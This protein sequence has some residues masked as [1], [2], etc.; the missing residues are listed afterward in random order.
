MTDRMDYTKAGG[1]SWRTGTL[2]HKNQFSLDHEQGAYNGWENYETWNVALYIGND[3]DLYLLAL[4][5]KDYEEFKANINAGR[6]FGPPPNPTCVA[7]TPDGVRWS[8]PKVNVDEI[9]LM[10]QELT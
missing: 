9:N 6:P 7:I 4:D 8:D 1:K 3:W 2:T 5:C 10:L